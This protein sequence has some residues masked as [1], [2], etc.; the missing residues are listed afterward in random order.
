MEC[1]GS[2]SYSHEIQSNGI[3]DEHIF[4]NQR[5]ASAEGFTHRKGPPAE[6]DLS[7]LAQKGPCGYCSPPK[8]RRQ[9]QTLRCSGQ[10]RVTAHD[11]ISYSAASRP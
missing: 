5:A 6:D 8:A 10:N 3:A 11:V 9:F 4:V 2:G 7:R 1:D